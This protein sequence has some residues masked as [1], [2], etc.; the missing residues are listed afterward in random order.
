MLRAMSQVAPR[1]TDT[2]QD[3][4]PSSIPQEHSRLSLINRINQILSA[5]SCTNSL[6]L[7]ELRC[8]VTDVATVLRNTKQLI[9]TTTP[10]LSTEKP[11]STES[12]LLQVWDDVQ[13][14]KQT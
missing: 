6:E 1:A 4:L 7:S 2:H 10:R 5:S 3:S 8:L 13:Q 14:L 9:T 11:T 12:L